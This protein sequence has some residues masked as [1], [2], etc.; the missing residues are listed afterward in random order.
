MTAQ[1]TPCIGPSDIPGPQ[2]QTDDQSEKNQSE[3]QMEFKA[4]AVAEA[5]QKNFANKILSNKS[6][7]K[8]LID[9][10]SAKLLDNLHLL[11]FVYTKNKK[12]SEKTTKNIIK[13]AVKL[14]LLLHGDKLS[15]EEKEKLM[16]IR[17]N[18]R[19]IAMTLISFFEVDHTY[20]RNF[21]VKYLTDL[22]TMLKT[23][24]SKHLTE[25][26]VG[27][28]EQIFG[29]VKTPDF[30]DNIYVPKKNEEMRIIM[31]EVVKDLN[32]CLDSN[33]L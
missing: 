29:V 31:A 26:S 17:S 16:K 3:L 18:I 5:V 6:V 28:V 33:F 11:L 25:K 20:D 22:E 23:L 9:D 2:C 1:E 24:I 10:S 12:D 7:A 21:V 4:K 27:R 32:I 14:A 30:L 19:T 15:N 8:N 13:I